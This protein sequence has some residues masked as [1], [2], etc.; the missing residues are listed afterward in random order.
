[1]GK[2]KTQD[3]N[4]GLKY[5]NISHQLLTSAANFPTKFSNPVSVILQSFMHQ[6][7]KP[8]FSLCFFD[9]NVVDHPCISIFDLFVFLGSRSSYLLPVGFLLLLFCFSV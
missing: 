9:D 2:K 5:T 8:C 3:G 7:D 4:L 1:M 6:S